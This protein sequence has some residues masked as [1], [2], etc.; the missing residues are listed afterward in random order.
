MPNEKKGKPDK[1]PVN[2]RTGQPASTTNPGTWSSC[3]EAVNFY[4][5]NLGKAHSVIIK[6]KVH[7]GP[8]AG[9][10]FVLTETDPYVG[11]DIDGCI[12]PDGNVIPWVQEIINRMASYVEVSP[13]GTGI[14]IFVKGNWP[15][16]WNK[17][18]AKGLEVYRAGRYLTVTGRAI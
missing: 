12:A 8:V 16:S 7:A 14:R 13:S 1:L 15:Y 11:I 5:H 17:N 18:S 10:G 4:Q 9:V 6:G 2:A 3:G